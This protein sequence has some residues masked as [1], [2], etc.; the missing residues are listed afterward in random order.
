M[1]FLETI[2][3]A[4]A[5]LERNGRVSFRALQRE[6]DLADSASLRGVQA[7][8]MARPAAMMFS[9]LADIRWDYCRGGD[10]GRSR[11]GA[12]WLVKDMRRGPGTSRT[13]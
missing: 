8:R 11:E 7:R 5:F 10:P 13:C 12:F 6:F 9:A 3:Q 2:E 1:S 4:R